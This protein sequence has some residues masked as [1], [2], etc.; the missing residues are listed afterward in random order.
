MIKKLVLLNIMIMASVMASSPAKSGVTPSP[1]V[2]EQTAIMSQDYQQ[3]GLVAKVQRI[4]AE[5]L[6]LGSRDDREEVY[7]SFPVILGSYADV[8]DQDTVVSLLQQELFDGPWPTPTMAEHY[9]EMSYD[10]FHLSGTVLGWY[11]LS[12]EG[13]YYEGSQSEP[14]DNGFG[15]PPGGT[16]SFLQESLDQAD[17]DV[18]F[19]RYDNDGPDGVANSGDDD[20]YVD[21]A[22]F[23][24]SGRG[25]EGGGAYIW[26]HRWVYSGWWGSAYTTND[27]SANG[28]FI[29]VND[30]IIQPAVS[31]GS[32]LI[33]I[34]VFS[35]EFGHALGL[36]DLYDTDYSSGG[37]G[38]WCLMASGS[39]STPSSPVHM[40]AWCKEMLGWLEPYQLDENIE[41]L[42]FPTAAAQPFAAKLW[43]HGELDY[44]VGSYSQGQ[45]VGREYYLIENRQRV[46]TEQH[47]PGTGLIIWHI[48]NS[49]WSNSNEN[50]RMVDVIAADGYFNGSSPGDAWPGT[51]NNRNFDFETDPSAV[52]WNGENTEVAVLNISDNDT[53]MTANVEVHE[54]NPH[55][56]ISDFNISDENNDHIYTAGETIEVWL[57]IE[58]TG[59]IANNLTATFSHV[60][61]AVEVI[62]EEIVF[63]PIDFMEMTFAS[64]PFEFQIS[65]SLEPQAVTF[66]IAFLADEMAIAEH[67][68]MVL[69]LGA[70]EVALVDDDGVIGGAGDYRSYYADALSISNTVYSVWDVAQ[71]GLPESRWLEDT[72]KVLWFTG[73]QETPLDVER[74]ELLSNYF[75]N[76]GRVLLTGKDIGDEEA[77]TESFLAEYFGAQV[78]QTSV[79]SAYVYG[80]TDHEIMENIDR[81]SLASSQG[82]NNQDTPDGLFAIEGGESLYIYPFLS[83]VS[84]GTSKQ[85]SIFSSIFLGFG[86]EA[87]APFSGNADTTRALILERMVAWLDL[88][89]TGILDEHL[90]LATRSAIVAAYPNP[91]NPEI[92]FS[93]DVIAGS[94]ATIEIYDLAGSRVSTLD[95]SG[96]GLHTWKPGATLAGGLYIARLYVDGIATPS[97]YKL[98]YLK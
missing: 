91:F 61:D 44:Y 75:D 98:T 4:K 63:G 16:G 29:R 82:A 27:A 42:E 64:D 62:S 69:L 18:D 68:E 10:Q 26:S 46:G 50:H 22:F 83:N 89:A 74:I 95:L 79:N 2:V 14:Y 34:G 48:D 3:G 86:F 58:N 96:S 35:H 39:W 93:L 9:L 11:E 54:S 20:G 90:Q 12:R 52:G 72:P 6:E 24:H 57:T 60:G 7:M 78:S 47:L 30:Y 40:S 32:G 70:P 33:E 77:E 67:H 17:I 66:D 65:D 76:G 56:R 38:S 28:G 8:D 49:Q 13:D 1:T 36:P 94:R 43:T 73:D 88:T 45:N 5:N 15:D 85:T 84:A 87:L 19:A 59:G 51:T 31:T 55:I 97:M 23:V 81:F 21:A 25:G 37:V 80:D 71:D 53:L 92:K 41:G